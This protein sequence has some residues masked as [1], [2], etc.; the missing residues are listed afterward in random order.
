MESMRPLRLSLL[1]LL[2]LT[3][4]ARA[5][6]DRPAEGQPAPSFQL[7][8]INP[9][10]SGAALVSL[11]HF[12]G[13]EPEDP[14]SRAVLLSFFASWCAPCQKEMPYLQQ[15]HQIYREQGLRVISVNIDREEEGLAL[16]R[17]QIGAAKV[18]YPVLSDRFNLLAR[19][20]LGEQSPL[21]SVFVIRRDGT[22]AR[23]ERGYGKDVKSFL[24]AEVQRALDLARPAAPKPK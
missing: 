23:I 20:Y 1:S 9:E 21:P 3:F 17:R 24:L 19:R 5:D 11:E 18:T 7:R 6:D 10:A 2:A 22:I 12:A 13:Q 14:G 4:A 8:A 15:L 16:A